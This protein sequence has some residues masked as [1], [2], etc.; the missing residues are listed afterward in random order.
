[1]SSDKID[2]LPA[3]LKKIIDTENVKMIFGVGRYETQNVT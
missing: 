2:L 1:M 3:Y